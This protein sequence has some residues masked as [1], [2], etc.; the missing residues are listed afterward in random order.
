MSN[1]KIGSKISDVYNEAYAKIVAEKSE[2][3]AKAHLSEN[4]GYGIG[5]KHNENL[6]SITSH[7]TRPIE[8]GNVFLVKI[9]IKGLTSSK[10]KKYSF[11]LADTV[12]V[13]QNPTNLT[14]SLWKEFKEISYVLSDGESDEE[15]EEEE[16]AGRTINPDLIIEKK[17]RFGAK[18]G[19]EKKEE[20][21]DEE[22]WVKH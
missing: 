10:G 8:K 3:W 15:N 7:N 9:Y 5:F 18:R 11:A 17:T 20:E 13:K 4:F 19:E 2:E 16:K 12:A 1:L 22:D 14:I 6:L 21:G